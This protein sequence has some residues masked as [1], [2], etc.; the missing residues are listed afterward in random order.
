M[1][2]ILE[3]VTTHCADVDRCSME[4]GSPSFSL[5]LTQPYSSSSPLWGWKALLL[6]VTS[7]HAWLW[8]WLCYRQ[9][10][11]YW[12][13]ALWSLLYSLAVFLFVYLIAIIKRY[14]EQLLMDTRVVALPALEISAM[15]RVGWFYGHAPVNGYQGVRRLSSPRP[16]ETGKLA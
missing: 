16:L 4:F 9:H 3:M 13:V 7:S 12:F 14:S 2:C 5:L 11:A 8:Q 10:Q 6:A 1:A 15:P